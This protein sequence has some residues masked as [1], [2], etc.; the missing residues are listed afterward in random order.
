MSPE[1]HRLI[2]AA[3]WAMVDLIDA[4]VGRILECLEETGQAESTVVLF[5]SDHGELLGDH[6]IYLKGPHFYEEAVRV[7][8]I[9]AGAGVI[10]GSRRSEAWVELVDLAPTLLEAA[11]LPRHP[12]MQGRSLWPMLQ[13]R[14]DIDHHREDVSTEYHNAGFP[15]HGTGV[16]ATMLR[17]DRY[18]MVRVHGSE[19]GELYDLQADPGEITNRWA[20]P[21]YQSVR[22]DLLQR[23]CDRMAWTVDPLPSREAVW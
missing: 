6:G 11:G 2:R 5:M 19:P 3:Y 9:I 21:E 15:H 16:Y 17:T 14:A 20:D 10:P 13:S 12:G 7:P 4:Q 18:K 1:D 8:L 22:C 23:L